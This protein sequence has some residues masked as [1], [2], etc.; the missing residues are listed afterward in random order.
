V[1]R[2]PLPDDRQ[3]GSPLGAKGHIC[4]LELA[5]AWRH[6]RYRER[7]ARRWSQ[8]SADG[9]FSARSWSLSLYI[10]ICMAAATARVMGITKINQDLN[11][12]EELSSTY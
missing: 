3:I 10:Y 5:C 1:L 7:T 8:E 6:S 2:K 11:Q 4:E 9:P 12:K